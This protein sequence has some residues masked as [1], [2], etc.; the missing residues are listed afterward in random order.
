MLFLTYCFPSS[1]QL[2][3]VLSAFSGQRCEVEASDCGCEHGTC[4]EDPNVSCICDLGW[5]GYKCTEKISSCDYN[6]C[7][8]GT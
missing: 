2:T 6:P 5:M 1:H 8:N 3:P 4:S 7:Q